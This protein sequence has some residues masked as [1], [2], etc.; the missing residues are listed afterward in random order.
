MIHDDDHDDENDDNGD[1]DDDDNNDYEVVCEG[2]P[3]RC[4]GF[5][6]GGVF[7]CVFFF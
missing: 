4:L 1:D 3:C 6:L 5:N 7:L 2:I